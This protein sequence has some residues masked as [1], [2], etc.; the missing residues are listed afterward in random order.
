MEGIDVKPRL[1]RLRDRIPELSED[2]AQFIAAMVSRYGSGKLPAPFD[3]ARIADMPV[4][5][6]N[7]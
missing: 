2:D 3:V 4:P 7:L 6:D 1:Y 5:G